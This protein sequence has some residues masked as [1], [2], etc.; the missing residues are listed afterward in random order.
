MIRHHTGGLFPIILRSKRLWSERGRVSMQA[1]SIKYKILCTFCCE[2][3]VV[4]AALCCVQASG[5]AAFRREHP[6]FRKNSAVVRVIRHGTR[7]WLTPYR[8]PR[9]SSFLSCALRFPD[10]HLIPL[11]MSFAT[12][13]PRRLKFQTAL[14]GPKLF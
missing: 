2:Q 5:E 13:L 12:L 10:L 3:G 6:R 1:F 14:M 8:R 11:N 7:F 4:Q 9:A